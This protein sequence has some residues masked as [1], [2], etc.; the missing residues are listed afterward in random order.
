S[1]ADRFNLLPDDTQFVFD[2]NQPQKS[3]GNSGELVAANRKTFPALISTGS[4]MVIGRIGP[5]GMNTF[6]IHPRS[7]E[8]QL[9]VQGRLVTKMTPENGVLNVNGNRR[10]IRNVIGPY[11]MTPFYQG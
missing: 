3:A 4:G 10:V 6:H 8:L 7:A 1:V 5:Y 2:F 9:V 11:Q